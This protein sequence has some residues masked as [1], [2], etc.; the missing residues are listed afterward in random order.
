M[1]KCKDFVKNLEMGRLSWMIS[2]G[3]CCHKSTVKGRDRDKMMKAEREREKI[4][5]KH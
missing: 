3:Q 2:W 4:F 1:E 5:C